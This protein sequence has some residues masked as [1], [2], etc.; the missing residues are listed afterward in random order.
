MAM[1]GLVNTLCC[2]VCFRG[3][4]LASCCAH[5]FQVWQAFLQGGERHSLQA[6]GQIQRPVDGDGFISWADSLD[7]GILVPRT[8]CAFCIPIHALLAG[9]LYS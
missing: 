4:A 9:W 8:S 6:L 1:T 3:T 7:L 5:T 2:S